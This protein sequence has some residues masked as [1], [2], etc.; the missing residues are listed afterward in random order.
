MLV[1]GRVKPHTALAGDFQSGLLKML[2]IGL[3]KQAGANI[4][5]RAIED[6]GFDQ[7]VRSVGPRGPRRSAVSWRAWRSWKTPTTKRP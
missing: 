7:I 3:G 2:L 6:Y 1:C 5:H 4:Y